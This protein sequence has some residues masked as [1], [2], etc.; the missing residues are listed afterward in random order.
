MTSLKLEI[1]G[2]VSLTV[3]VNVC[4]VNVS[5]A[6]PPLSFNTTLTVAEPVASFAGV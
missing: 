1:I 6:P 4:V 2:V 3:M 5:V